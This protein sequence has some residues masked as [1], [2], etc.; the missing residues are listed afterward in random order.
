[1]NI[2][3]KLWKKKGVSPL[4]ATV[5]LI[6]FAVSLGA[7]VMNWGRGYVETTM[8]QADV[9]SAEKLTCSMETG[10]KFVEVRGKQRLCIDDRYGDVD[11]PKLKFTL[12]NT[13]TSEL[14]GM[15]IYTIPSDIDV[16][17]RENSTYHD[18][19]D[20]N[21]PPIAK[22]EYMKGE[23]VLP[24]DTIDITSI[25]DIDVIEIAPIILVKGVETVCTEHAVQRTPAQIG[26]C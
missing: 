5:L 21:K 11:G 19:D 1:M 3:K 18:N 25:D 14:K 6:A 20:I 22:S 8:T 4:I 9:Q 10:F 7:V 24:L 26:D 16:I 2:F 23:L 17:P 13:G 12:V 15:R